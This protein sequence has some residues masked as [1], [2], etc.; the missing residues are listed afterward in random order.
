MKP[1]GVQFTVVLLTCLFAT[2]SPAAEQVYPQGKL[3]PFMG[4]SGVPA[5]DA[6]HGFSVAGPTYSSEQ[7]RDLAVAEA[8]GLR[9]S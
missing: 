6:R 7:E 2:T 3:F 9:F 8:A 4:Y 1:V 5:R